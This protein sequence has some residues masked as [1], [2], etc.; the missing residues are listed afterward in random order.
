M[1]TSLQI[2]IVALGLIVFTACGGGG[3]SSDS[4]EHEAPQTEHEA[5]QTEHEAPQTE[6]EAPPAVF[7][8]K[9]RALQIIIEY[10]QTNG[11]S[12]I[13]VAQ[14]YAYAGVVGIGDDNVN[15]FNEVISGLIPEEVDTTEELQVLLN[16]MGASTNPFP[17]I[18]P[19]I[20]L[21]SD[22]PDSL[23]PEAPHLTPLV[24]EGSTTTIPVPG[25]FDF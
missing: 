14:T 9:V 11:T 17:I 19:Q 10:A 20:D 18:P 1:K 5:P 24:F 15:D 4:T 13:P 25:N 21:W 22:L 8:T 2:L 23:Y 6:S 7:D 12:A 16:A 3:G